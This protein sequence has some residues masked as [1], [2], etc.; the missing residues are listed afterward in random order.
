MNTKGLPPARRIRPL[1][2]PPVGECITPTEKEILE[3]QK[4]KAEK[5]AKEIEQ[6]IANEGN[7]V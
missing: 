1:S 5:Y 6:K 3:A 2:I 7:K 4:R